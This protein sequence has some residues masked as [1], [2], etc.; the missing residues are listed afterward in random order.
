M[1]RVCERKIDL[2]PSALLPAARGSSGARS[3]GGRIDGQTDKGDRTRSSPRRLPRYACAAPETFTAPNASWQSY[4]P[5]PRVN[6][7]QCLDCTAIDG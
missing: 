4:S 1:F 5:P 7:P 6:C 3:N 2:S